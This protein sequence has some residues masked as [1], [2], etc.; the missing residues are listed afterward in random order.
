MLLVSCNAGKELRILKIYLFTNLIRDICHELAHIVNA[1]YPVTRN[2]LLKVLLREREKK[3]I[4]ST[5]HSI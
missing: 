2:S 3:K 5:N 4:T 1:F